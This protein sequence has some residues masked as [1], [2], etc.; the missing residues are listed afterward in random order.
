MKQSIFDSIINYGL[1]IREFI[2]HFLKINLTIF[3]I[4]SV[5][6]SGLLLAGIIY[7][8]AKSHIVSLA[9]EQ[10]M[11]ILGAAKM[12]KRRIIKGWKQI[13]RRLRKMDEAQ[14]KLAIIEADKLLDEVLKISGYA[15]ETMADRL[16][17]LT[18]AQ[19]SNLEEIWQVH[20]IRNQI[21]HEPDFKLNQ[22]EAAY[23]ISIYE[24]A[25]KE[26][27]LLD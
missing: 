4:I 9:I 27:G 14:Y 13:F 17:Q 16:K 24:K 7:I 8:L 5:F 22:T 1:Y 25:L 19:I 6:V 18:P 3:Q 12:P 2:F 10:Y 21:V 15:G 11:D 23:A 26:F 20:K